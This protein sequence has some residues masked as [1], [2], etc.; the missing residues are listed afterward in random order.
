MAS[1]TNIPWVVYGT[2]EDGLLNGIYVNTNNQPGQATMKLLD[3][4]VRHY[5][6]DTK[7]PKLYGLWCILMRDE[8]IPTY[9]DQKFLDNNINSQDGVSGYTMDLLAQ[10]HNERHQWSKLV[11]YDKWLEFNRNNRV[12]N[13][14]W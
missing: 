8:R 6:N 9:Y 12:F 11:G 14:I 10:I 1:N 3:D 5:D 4:M 7:Y 13:S 2:V